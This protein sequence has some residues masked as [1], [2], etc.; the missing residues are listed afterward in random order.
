MQQQMEIKL[1]EVWAERGV[2][3]TCRFSANELAILPQLSKKETD[4]DEERDL[5]F[6]VY[7][8]VEKNMPLQ[9][10]P[11]QCLLPV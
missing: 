1:A 10:D 11:R 2:R 8:Q 3:R 5:A 4:W 7:Q 9:S 6:R